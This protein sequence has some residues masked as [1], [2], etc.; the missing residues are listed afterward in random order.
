MTTKQ[1]IDVPA[2][3][4]K[5]IDEAESLRRQRDIAIMKLDQIA[6]NLTESLGHERHGTE[7]RILS[8]VI[9]AGDNFKIAMTR[10]M[11]MGRI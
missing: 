11:K 6:S 2:L 1:D 3:V 9:V 7:G 5:W 8:G 4:E 10:V